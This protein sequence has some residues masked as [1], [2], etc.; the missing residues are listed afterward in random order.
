MTAVTHASPAFHP[1]IFT[2]GGAA[3]Q[4]VHVR[5]CRWS[6]GFSRFLQ[7]PPNAPSGIPPVGGKELC[8]LEF[9]LQPGETG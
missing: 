9:R 5:F 7:S 1:I 4:G 8:A 2:C 3:W 6:S